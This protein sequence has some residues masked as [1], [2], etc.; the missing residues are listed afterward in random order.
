[1]TVADGFQH[2]PVSN[3]LKPSGAD[4]FQ[5]VFLYPCSAAAI[6]IHQCIFKETMMKTILAILAL[7][8]TTHSG[9]SFAESQHPAVADAPATIQQE[10]FE[11][12]VLD[13]M[14][15]GGYT[16]IQLTSDKGPVWIAAP[17][18][19]LMKGN[20]L[21]HS[22]GAEMINFHSKTLDRTFESITF[23]GKAWVVKK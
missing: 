13:M 1:I 11:G 5:A 3:F 19:K 16:Y 6:P 15:A 18:I 2:Y 12:E 14:D 20:K 17:R 9:I 4:F 22:G 10:P 21:Q 8:L 7:A 23:A